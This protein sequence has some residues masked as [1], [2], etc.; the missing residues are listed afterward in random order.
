MLY[1]AQPASQHL[2]VLNWLDSPNVWGT[3]FP[4][5]LRKRN[6][7]TQKSV[8]AK[9]PGRL[10]SLLEIVNAYAGTA[11]PASP[12]LGAADPPATS[13]TLKRTKRRTETF[14]PSLAIACVIISPI[15]TDSSL[16]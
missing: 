6:F 8:P 9:K 13:P 5:R 7:V 16:M 3:T 1:A 4:C 11:T 15:V 12:A 2:S 10:K 14:S